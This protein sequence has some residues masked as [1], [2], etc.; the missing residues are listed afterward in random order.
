MTAATLVDVEVEHRAIERA[1]LQAVVYAD[2][3]DYPL[4]AVE[5]HRYL[6]G[7]RASPAEVEAALREARYAS[8]WWSYHQGYVTLP[9]R[10]ALV[11]TRRERAEW[12]ATL[13]PKALRYG[14]II[15][16]MPFVRMVAVTG[17]LAVDNVRPGADID[18][19]IVVEP[20]RLWLC[21]ALV[22]ALV[23]LVARS[24]DVVCPNYL[25]SE[26]ALVLQ[27]RSL[28]SAHEL[29]Q[30]VPLAGVALYEHMRRLN[31]WADDFLP[32][33]AGPP[34]QIGSPRPQ[35]RTAQRVAEAPLRT[36]VGG[37]LERQEMTRKVRKLSRLRGS[38][39]ETDFCA[40]WCKGHF[41]AHGQHTLDAF[42]E[43]LRGFG[44]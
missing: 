2:I 36:P 8:R 12:A 41:E 32:N 4:T 23:R 5:V 31:N 25:I 10:A 38:S 35:H 27:D 24:G 19:L 9:D 11:D 1:V 33:A 18:Y 30:M 44:L 14:R 6:V 13:W 20:G 42:D 22:I 37:W 40:D 7:V 39:G 34:R 21:R 15:A 28:Y 26:R 43:R 17:A 3:F 29:A 16:N